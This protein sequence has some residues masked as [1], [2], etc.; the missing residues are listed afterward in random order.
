M[1]K[2]KTPVDKTRITERLTNRY[3]TGGFL[4]SVRYPYVQWGGAGMVVLPDGEPMYSHGVRQ[5]VWRTFR[6]ATLYPDMY[7]N[8]EGADASLAQFCLAPTGLGF[9]VRVVHAVISGCIPLIIQDNVTQPYQVNEYTLAPDSEREGTTL[10]EHEREG[11]GM[12]T[13]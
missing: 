2:R 12:L 7:I 8:R 3:V 11:V 4:L 13:Y 6:N 10:W 9:G 5:R 1:D